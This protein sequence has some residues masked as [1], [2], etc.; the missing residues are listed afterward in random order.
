[1]TDYLPPGA[2]SP[3][4]ILEH[5]ATPA[6][7]PVIEALYATIRQRAIDLPEGS[8]TVTLLQGHE[9]KL[10]KKIGEEATEVVMAAKSNDT[11]QLRYESV[12]LLYHL[13]VVC[14]RWG[15]TLDDLAA[16]LQSRFK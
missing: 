1:M 13:L 12:D 4:D 8:Y 5:G 6:F 15:V 2:D 9:D 11:D 10:L 16:E 7:G 14:S 3:E